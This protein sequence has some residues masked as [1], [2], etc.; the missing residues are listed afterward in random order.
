[1][2][3]AFHPWLE[4]APAAGNPARACICSC[5]RQRS[6]QAGGQS[7]A[8]QGQRR[9]RSGD[10][11]TGRRVLGPG[12]ADGLGLEFR[13]QALAEG[14][15]ESQRKSSPTPLYWRGI[16]FSLSQARG[17]VLGNCKQL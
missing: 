7:R 4:A 11:G 9:G 15:E 2:K 1:M 3:L 5:T 12:A 8:P 14:W 16:S 6:Q 10:A 13:D 17:R